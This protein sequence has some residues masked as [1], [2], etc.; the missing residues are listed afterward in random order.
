MLTC[1]PGPEIAGGWL[2]TTLTDDPGQRGVRVEGIVP[3]GVP[4]V[5]IKKADG[6]ASLANVEANS[7]SSEVSE[8]R[9]VSYFRGETRYS[10]PVP[11]APSTDLPPLSG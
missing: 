8:P 7:Y 9:E 1:L 11:T 10:V 4:V 3:N 5:A 6:A 2:L